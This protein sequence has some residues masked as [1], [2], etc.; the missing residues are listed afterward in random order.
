V[1]KGST[2]AETAVL[3]QTT[4]WRLEEL[5]DFRA[6]VLETLFREEADRYGMKVRDF[7]LPFYVALSGSRVW[8]PLYDSMEVLGPDLTRARLRS[9]IALLGGV[10]K[11]KLKEL[12]REHRNRTAGGEGAS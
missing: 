2:P 8:T 11:K 9:A 1:G 3:L 10:S 7:N 4:L 12:E 6:P 5:V